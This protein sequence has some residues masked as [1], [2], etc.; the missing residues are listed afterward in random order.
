MSNEKKY[1]CGTSKIVGGT[2]TMFVADIL[3]EGQKMAVEFVEQDNI[4]KPGKLVPLEFEKIQ[5]V[6]FAK[7][8]GLGMIE[9]PNKNNICDCTAMNGIYKDL[10][11][12]YMYC[13]QC[14]REVT[15]LK[16]KL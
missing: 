13:N 5:G 3:I 6:M 1:Y 14:H 4:G 11:T 8:F 10:I 7:M 2:I 12:E 15:G 9:A 16:L